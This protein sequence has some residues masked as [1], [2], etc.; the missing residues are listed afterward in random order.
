MVSLY[1]VAECILKDIIIVN[2]WHYEDIVE[3][4][5]C[6]N[7][8]FDNIFN[9]YSIAREID[10]DVLKR[11]MMFNI[12]MYAY[13]V[14]LYNVKIGLDTSNSQNFV[15]YIEA[16]NYKEIVALFACHS[17]EIKIIFEDCLCYISG[18]YIFRYCCWMNAYAQ[19]R[20]SSILKLNPFALL[21]MQDADLG[22][23]FVESEV[24]IQLFEDLY[25][26]ALEEAAVN[27]EYEEDDEEFSK[28]LVHCLQNKIKDHFND[29]IGKINDFCAFLL[30]SV[31][32]NITINLKNSKMLKKK[33]EAILSK[34]GE[35]E[36]L[37]LINLFM[38]S[39]HFAY[40]I[41]NVFLTYN[42][43]LE[44]EELI[45]R[46]IIFMKKGNMKKL[47]EINPFYKNDVEV[48]KRHNKR[49]SNM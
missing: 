16:L 38:D 18:S 11:I 7:N 26:K 21:E 36:L 14:N 31:Y 47:A 29:D 4:L 27:A 10:Y 37:E 25:N 35:Y 44:K 5:N 43:G 23:G 15:N 20:Q 13:L 40:D 1:D 24:Y 8:K 6:E 30:S 22:D 32:E 28:L 33:Y 34:Y 39:Y 3:Y 19:G 17:P 41:I 2:N 42:D 48:L 45:N 46:R 12:F 49:S 9:T